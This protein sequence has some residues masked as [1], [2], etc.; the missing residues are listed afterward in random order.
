MK[1]GYKF[2]GWPVDDRVLDKTDQITLVP[3]PKYWGTKPKL[4]KVIFKIQADTSAEFTAFKSDQVAMI[5][6]QP[7]LDAVD[8]INAGLPNSQKVISTRTV[9]CI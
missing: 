3:N 7:Q 9:E 1:D 4:D 8:Q 2:S 6:P 5:Y